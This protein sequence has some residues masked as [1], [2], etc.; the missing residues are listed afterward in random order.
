MPYD[1]KCLQKEQEKFKT[2]N[3]INIRSFSEMNMNEIQCQS[4][5]IN[6]AKNST[7]SINNLSQ[8]E[9]FNR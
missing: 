4:D 8:I 1:Y 6:L 7:E 3:E 2:E 9:K 5:L